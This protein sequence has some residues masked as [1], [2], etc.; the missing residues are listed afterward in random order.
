MGTS[1]DNL[2]GSRELTPVYLGSGG[3]SFMWSGLASDRQV[4]VCEHYCKLTPYK[5]YHSVLVTKIIHS[6]VAY[7]IITHATHS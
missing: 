2:F 7:G 1:N 4:P 6:L 5:Q 3:L